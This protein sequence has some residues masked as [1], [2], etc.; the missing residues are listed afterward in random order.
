MRLYRFGVTGK[1]PGVMSQRPSSARQRRR[2]FR[3]QTR[4]ASGQGLAPCVDIPLH[5]S[6]IDARPRAAIHGFR[7]K[8][9]K[10]ASV[11]RKMRSISIRRVASVFASIARMC[12]RAVLTL[13]PLA[14]AA[15]ETV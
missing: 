8:G 11:E 7:M 14:L 9:H 4:L 5:I 10:M 6:G 12:E 13:T 1:S 3:R 2:C 15:S